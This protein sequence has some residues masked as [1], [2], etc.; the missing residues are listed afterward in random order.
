ME[1][2]FRSGQ[3]LADQDGTPSAM[4]A[5]PKTRKLGERKLEERARVIRPKTLHGE[6]TVGTNRKGHEGLAGSRVLF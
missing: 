5:C 3:A 2:T 6:A 4:E 1:E